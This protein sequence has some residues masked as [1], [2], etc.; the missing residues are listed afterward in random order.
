MLGLYIVFSV[1]LRRDDYGYLSIL[2]DEKIFDLKVLGMLARLLMSL[3]RFDFYFSTAIG[4][5]LIT[6]PNDVK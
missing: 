2:A 6:K 1:F 5:T 3:A 4:L